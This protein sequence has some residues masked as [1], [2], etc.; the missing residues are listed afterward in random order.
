MDHVEEDIPDAHISVFISVLLNVGDSLVLDAD[1][2]GSFGFGS[3]SRVSRVV[4]H[5]LKRVN[6]TQR[7]VLLKSAIEQGCAIG[8]QR[9]LIAALSDE[10]TKE[11]ASGE[12]ALVD[13]GTLDELK[14]CWLDGLRTKLSQDEML[15]HL[16]LANLLAAW[17][18]WGNPVEARTWC[19]AATT[20]NDGLLAF[21]S[22]FCWYTSSQTMGD[23]AVR[24]QPR[25]NPTD[26]EP[27]LDTENCAQRL[28]DL[29]ESGAVPD[30][31]REA[32]D[33]F[34]REFEML[35]EGINPEGIGVF[36]D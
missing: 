35:K 8:V 10:V 17:C 4:Y 24:R 34:L 25:L 36:D 6:Q 3:E 12:E 15:A 5:L 27:Y 19:E 20:S 29:R 30:M 14:S 22:K 23:W 11:A 9:Y 31:A 26:L 33:Q 2:R 1:E 18:L 21:L 32:V 16:K 13:S 7:D 28:I